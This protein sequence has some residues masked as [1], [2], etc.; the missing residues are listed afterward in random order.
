MIIKK[1]EFD[2][3]FVILTRIHKDE[4]GYLFESYAKNH[5]DI[6]GIRLYHFNHEIV[7]VSNK[8]VFRGLHF[9]TQP[10]SQGKLVQVLS[11]EVLDVVVDIRKSSKTFGAYYM[12]ALNNE[13]HEGYQRQLWIPP[14]FAHGF[15]SLTDDTVFHY[16][17]TQPREASAERILSI[18]EFDFGWNYDELIM[19]EKDK[20]GIT[21]G[22]L[23]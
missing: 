20:N 9:Q 19:S 12:T 5:N 2:G 15:L 22:E 8:N 16:K 18:K 6:P 21:L 7:S 4:R 13:V 17:C 11:G 14:G 1:T 10:D 3:L 23:K